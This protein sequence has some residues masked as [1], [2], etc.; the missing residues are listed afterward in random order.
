MEYCVTEDHMKQNIDNIL[1]HRLSRG[2]ARCQSLAMRLPLQCV[3]R[4]K[5]FFCDWGPA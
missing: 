3:K 2:A 1:S 5:D 4:S